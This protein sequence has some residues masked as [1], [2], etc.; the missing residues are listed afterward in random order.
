MPP[1]TDEGVYRKF[2]EKA[3]FPGIFGG[4][5]GKSLLFADYSCR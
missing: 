5:G 2:T 4:A 3:S 1:A